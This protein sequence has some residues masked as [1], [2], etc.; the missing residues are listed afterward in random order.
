MKDFAKEKAGQAKAEFW[1]IQVSADITENTIEYMPENHVL[2]RA[3]SID[4]A[5]SLVNRGRELI[6]KYSPQSFCGPVGG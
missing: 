3:N 5:L 2:I 4:Y 1:D 6:A